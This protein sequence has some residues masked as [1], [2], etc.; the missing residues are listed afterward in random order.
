MNQEI[1]TAIK[2]AGL[3]QWQVAKACGVVESTFIRWMRDELTDERRKAIFEA[4]EALKAKGE[5]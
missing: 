1:R 5:A 4:I 2:A 3:R